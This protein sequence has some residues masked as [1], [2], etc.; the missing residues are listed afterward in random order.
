MSKQKTRKSITSRFKF[1]K[2]GKV[3]YRPAGQGHFN[4][5]D[6]GSKG[7]RKTKLVELSRSDVKAL[8]RHMKYSKK[9]GHK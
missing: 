9:W 7:R 8:K 2:S 6:R 3:L 1:T 4:A 5:K